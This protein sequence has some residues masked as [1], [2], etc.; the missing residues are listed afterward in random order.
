MTRQG[1][2]HYFP[3]KTDL[4]LAVL[5]QRD[6]DNERFAMES[7]KRHSENPT[8]SVMSVMQQTRDQPGIAR[9][10]AVSMAESSHPEHPAYSYFRERSR[11]GREQIVDGLLHRQERGRIR[12]DV[13]PEVFAMALLALI[14][15]LNLHLLFDPDL[16][17]EPSVALLLQ[18]LSDIAGDAAP[19][20]ESSR[21][22]E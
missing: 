3:S 14:D 8:A 1:L 18:G 19:A 10:V 5:D 2:L 13:N 11:H 16:D 4:L 7:S 6:H 21:T 9:L 17:V 12:R 22:D 20:T 15:G